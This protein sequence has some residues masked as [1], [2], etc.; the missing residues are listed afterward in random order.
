[1]NLKPVEKPTLQQIRQQT[2][3]PDGQTITRQLL[4]ERSGLQYSEVYIFDIGGHLTEA[5][6]RKMLRA[7]ND[8]SG[9]TLTVNDVKHGGFH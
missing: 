4:A 9:C 7:F 6:I 3:T 2:K 1:M 8:L 5:K